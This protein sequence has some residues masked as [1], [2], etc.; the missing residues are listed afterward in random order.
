[1]SNRLTPG[2]L[3]RDLKE[4]QRQIKKARELLVMVRQAE[5]EARDELAQTALK[6]G[7]GA[8]QRSQQTMAAITVESATEDVTTKELALMRSATALLVR[9]R[10]LANNDT[11][12]DSLENDVD[13]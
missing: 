4:A 2:T 11:S 10:K 1:M 9:L 12:P 3:L 7:R 6:A 8:L 5:P 13:E